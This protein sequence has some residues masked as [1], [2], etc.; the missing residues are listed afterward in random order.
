MNRPG[1][2]FDCGQNHAEGPCPPS[3]PRR[4]FRLTYGDEVLA[5]ETDAAGLLAALH[6]A[7]AG[8]ALS[9]VCRDVAPA[10]R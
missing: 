3:L 10:R 7:P 2:C 6:Q 5:Q 1:F 9:I 4:T 8:E